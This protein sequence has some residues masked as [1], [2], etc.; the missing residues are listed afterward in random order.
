MRCVSLCKLPL[1]M[2]MIVFCFQGNLIARDAEDLEEALMMKLLE[3]RIRKH[4]DDGDKPSRLDRSDLRSFKDKDDAAEISVG[5]VNDIKG[6]LKE[7]FLDVLASSELISWPEF[8]ARV[9]KAKKALE[10]FEVKY[11][12][13]LASGGKIVTPVAPAAMP[14]VMMPGIK[15][16]G[17]PGVVP[18]G[19]PVAKPVGM[20]G[21]VPIGMPVAK[22]VGMPSAMPGVVP[23]AMPIAKPAGMPGVVPVAMPGVKPAVKPADDDDDDDDE[24]EKPAVKPGMPVVKPAG[25]PG[26]VPVGM[27]GV[28]PVATMP[29]AMPAVMPGA[30]IPAAMP[31][32]VPV[33]M[34]IVMP[35][36][37]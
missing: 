30:G 22:P 5:V 35:S 20:P 2:A 24:D 6:T 10:M 25:M 19:M 23:V 26:V 4:G 21:V 28:V 17:M 29:G 36:A 11:K 37:K 9:N 31:G 3:K 1:M 8:A 12:G 13:Q 16:L 27:P 18:V 32:V 7:P 15:P 34:P 33:A 14:G